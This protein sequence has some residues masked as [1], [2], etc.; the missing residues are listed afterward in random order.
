[1]IFVDGESWPPSFHGTGTEEYFNDAWGFNRFT[2]APGAEAKRQEESIA[3]VSGVLLNGLGRP[4]GWYGGNAVFTFHISDSIP[5]EEHIEVTVEAGTENNMTNDYASTAY[6]YALPSAQDFFFM[7]PVQERE[8]VPPE[9]WKE[10]YDEALRHYRA[11][12]RRQVSDTVW[13]V[14]RRPTDARNRGVRNTMIGRTIRK[15]DLMGLR[16]EDREALEKQWREGMKRPPQEEWKTIDQ[17]ML[18]IGRKL[19]LGPVQSR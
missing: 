5:F 2:I 11:E 18:E 12:L 13:A 14:H 7:R 16:E 1:M 15:A 6:W 3:P 4:G 8:T 17:V 10:M 9:G 19:G